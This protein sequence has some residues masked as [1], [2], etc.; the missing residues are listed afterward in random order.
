M[1]ASTMSTAAENTASMTRSLA[2]QVFLAFALAYFLSALIRAIT[3]T[4]SPTLQQEFVLTSGDLGLLAGGYFLGFAL[5]QLPLGRWLDAYGP[6]RVILCF[7]AVAVAGCLAFAAAPHFIGLLAARVLCGI[8]VSACLMAPLT[9]YRLWFKPE[10]QLRASSWM[11][12]TGSLGM[13]AST[14]PVQWLLPQIGWRPIFVLLAVLVGLAM[15]VLAWRLPQPAPKRAMPSEGIISSYRV[16]WQHPYVKRHFWLG[17]FSYGGLM[18]MQTLWAGPWLVQVSGQTAAQAATGLFWLN[19][20]MLVTFWSWGVLNPYFT[21]RGW[22]ADR[23]LSY[24]M[25]C[26]LLMTAMIAWAGSAVSWWHWALFCMGSSFMSVALP[27]VGM[28][29]PKELAGRALSFY[30]LVIFA[31]VFVVQWGMGLLIDAF[32]YG[33]LNTEN[34]FRAALGVFLICCLGGY[35]R[36]VLDNRNTAQAGAATP[37]PSDPSVSA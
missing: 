15:L 16:I 12:M 14:L 29:F 26:A 30:N 22:D 27:A 4:L 1:N 11:L 10:S 37:A 5:T 3:A 18:A 33:G 7:L 23:L 2:V 28:A 6:K 9:A 36:F 17:F 21:R 24:G 19:V 35:L 31:G 25:P 32:K 34:A 13:V 20:C 8:G